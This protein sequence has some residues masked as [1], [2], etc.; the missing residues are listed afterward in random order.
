MAQICRISYKITQAC[1]EYFAPKM[2]NYLPKYTNLLTIEENC[3]GFGFYFN[4]I[5]SLF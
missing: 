1:A 4:Y 3:Y 2:A 5:K